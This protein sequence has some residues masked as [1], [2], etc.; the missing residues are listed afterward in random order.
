MR[1]KISGIFLPWKKI[2]CEIC[3]RDCT[4][5]YR[6][7]HKRVFGYLATTRKG[8]APKSSMSSAGKGLSCCLDGDLE[9]LPA[10]VPTSASVSPSYLQVESSTHTT[11]RGNLLVKED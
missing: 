8:R 7:T 10:P 6:V 11:A 3:S 1:I 5:H 2:I 4:A 9:T